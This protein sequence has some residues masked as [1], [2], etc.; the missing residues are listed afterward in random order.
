MAGERYLAEGSTLLHGDY[1]PGS[2]MT[3]DD[4]VFVIDPEFSF[5]GFPEFDL[6]VM[7]SLI[8]I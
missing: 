8:H 5:K 2:W 3:V 4:A 1:Y 7:L 6:G